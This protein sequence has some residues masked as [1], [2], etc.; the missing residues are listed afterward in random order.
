[1][2]T[3]DPMPGATIQKPSEV[4]PRNVVLIGA[5]G[6]IGASALRVIE[7]NPD[8]LRLVG[9]ANN[10]RRE[11]LLEISR[12]FS[13]PHATSF[14]RDGMQA[15]LDIATLPEAD[16]VLVAANGTVGLQPTLAAIRAGKDIALA[17]K[18][19][20]VLAGKFV[21]AEAA[22]R[23]AKI[24][25][26]DSE[27]NAIFQCLEGQN[28]AHLRRLI[29][30]AS[31]GPFRD[32]SLERMR[33]VTPAQALK[34][35][36]WDMGP[37]VTID[38]ATMANKGL[39]M[40][41]AHWLF[42]ARPSQLDV[43][44]HQ[45]SVVHSMVEFTDG[46]VIAQLSPPS[47]T[48]AIQHALLYPDRGSPV[49]NQ[50]DFASGLSLDFHAPDVERFRC[51]ALARKAMEAGGVAGAVFN[52][53]NEVAVEAFAGNKLPFLAIPSIIEHTLEHTDNFE[54]VSLDQVLDVDAQARALATEYLSIYRG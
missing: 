32:W 21:M 37:K 48:F 39:E 19:V 1:M 47:M 10:C 35:P 43:V 34:H 20:L 8:R 40:I 22:Q 3:L 46:S 38:S 42:N 49:V 12:R 16:I 24:L 2:S 45:Q 17:S 25:P 54:P 29:L 27:H 4:R 7:A 18:E 5:T 33:T 50:L 26:V 11:E 15:L 14:E 23:G 9:V 52:A 53:A 41:E 30:T 36:N 6:S 44:V 51:L 31:G 13:V 28:G